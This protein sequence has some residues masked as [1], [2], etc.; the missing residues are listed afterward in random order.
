M[1]AVENLRTLPWPKRQEFLKDHPNLMDPFEDRERIYKHNQIVLGWSEGAMRRF[2]H[3][4][5]ENTIAVIGTQL[6]D[7]AKGRIVDNK[8]KAILSIS[9][10]KIVH[11]VRFQG[12]NNAGHT[13]E[14]DGKRLD[15]HVVPSFIMYEETVGI[16]DQGMVIHPAD[17]KTEVEYVEDYVGDLRGKLFLS[18]DAILATD[19][20]RAEEVDNRQREN[21]TKGGTGR[22]IAPSYAH[23][24]D[25][26]GK[27]I[28][29]L[30][31]DKWREK[32]AEYYERKRE[33]FAGHGVDLATMEVPDFKKSRQ[34]G[35]EEKQTVGTKEEFLDKLEESRSWIISRNMAT[36]V[37]LMHQEAYWDV[38]K[39]FLF[40]GAQAAGLDSFTGTHPDRTSSNTTAYGIREGTAYWTPEKIKERIGV[41]KVPY[42]SSVGERKMPTHI[43]PD[44]EDAEWATWVREK[45]DEYGTTTGRPRDIVHLDLPFIAY[46]AAMAG[47]EEL[48]LTHL[49][50]ARKDTP[51][52]VCYTYKDK[53]TGEFV[54]YQPGLHYQK[55]VEPSYITLPG[56]D[57]QACRK[58][59]SIRELPENAIKFM[60][61]MQSRLGYPITV[62]TTGPDRHNY[63]ELDKALS[64]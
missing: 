64:V 43:Y 11:V 4:A 20:E 31:D 26:T 16:M 58:A 52:K 34:T 41:V 7:E 36:N 9:G 23:H 28:S 63:L 38:T 3:L 37:Y 8:I 61:F 44:S 60:A 51:I 47:I 40:E 6:G 39:G 5:R 27:H 56:W 53:D 25:K 48:A 13:V 1:Y 29:D 54:A 18:Q 46:N 12:G 14:K 19:I 35:K 32:F 57:G 50:I 45:A 22:G 10:V 17:L 24:E 42:M 30:L 33:D 49:D 55:N 59:K 15:L 62:A 21:A 2:E